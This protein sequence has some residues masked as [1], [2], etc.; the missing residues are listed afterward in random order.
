LP[1]CIEATP[2]REDA[3]RTPT[4]VHHKP[5]TDETLILIDMQVVYVTNED[6]TSQLDIDIGREP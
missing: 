1:L 3:Q 5:V 4:I 6:L 2:R